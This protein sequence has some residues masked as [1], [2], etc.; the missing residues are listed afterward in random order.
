MLVGWGGGCGNKKGRFF[1]NL[2]GKVEVFGGRVLI[3]SVRVFF[4]VL[5]SLGC[6]RIKDYIVY[7]W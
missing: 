3:S 2:S 6:Y 1:G 5:G 7:F 4:W